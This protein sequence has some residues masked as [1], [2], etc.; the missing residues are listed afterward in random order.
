MTSPT[1]DARAPESRLR[2][3]R[4]QRSRKS[5]ERI[6]AALDELIEEKTF[7]DITVTEVCKRAK[8]AVGTFYD[9]V[10]NKDALLEHLRA[11]LYV[12][13]VE[14]V[15]SL[16]APE[17]F[18]DLSLRETL[19]INAQEMVALHGTRQGAMRAI[20]VE[21][22]R[23]AAFADHARTLNRVLMERVTAPWLAKREQLRPGGEALVRSAFLMAAGF[24]R[25]AMIWSDLWPGRTEP[26]AL[27]AEL[28]RLLVS[29]LLPPTETHP[30]S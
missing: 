2:P 28:E 18:V 13:I 30:S 12:D 9:R 1:N 22:R 5:L 14:Q 23:S 4:Q 7:E 16:F 25:E 21:A 29:F 17:R 27:A 19:A 24:L 15:E 10:G 8:V 20:I 26:E 11:R 3:A 6:I